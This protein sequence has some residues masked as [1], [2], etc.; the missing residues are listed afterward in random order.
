MIN[1]YSLLQELPRTMPTFFLVRPA[2]GGGREA[3]E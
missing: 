1:N 2:D 3:A